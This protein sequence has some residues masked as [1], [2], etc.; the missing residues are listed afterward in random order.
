VIKQSNSAPRIAVIGCGAIAELYHLPALTQI[1]EIR[2]GLV[3]VDNNPSR[4]SAMAAKFSVANTSN[5][6]LEL[7]DNIDGAIVAT[8]PGSHFPIS[9]K[10]LE[11]SVHVLCE[12]PLSET[13]SEAEQLIG[14]AAASEVTLSVNQ[15]RRMFP[16]YQKIRQLIAAGTLGEIRSIRY[17]DGVEFSWPA[18]TGHH[19]CLG[20]KGAWSDTGI[21][22][23]DTICFW[24]NA[25]PLLVES[26]NDSFGGPEAVATVRLR[27]LDANIELKV[28]RLG[29]LSN[30]FHI[31]GTIGTIVAGNEDWQSIT[32]QFHNGRKRRLK[33]R[34]T[35]RGY[36]DFALPLM[37]N[38]VDVIKG[39]ASPLIPAEST[40]PG[41]AL[42]EEA[43]RKA[44][45]FEMPWNAVWESAN[46]S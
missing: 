20:A 29:R 35:A 7:I 15:T 18:A 41:V 33:L 11:N 26:R 16:T 8:P 30:Q 25:Q 46:V 17:H 39:I 31:E 23:L 9:A 6:Y 22:L 14:M 10:L 21:H 13:Y 3:L 28:S 32:I 19:F 2:S 44:T 45:P 40:L 24:L 34:T 4:L 42:L 5:N 27:H 1:P 12:K 36:N 37:Q 38:F 43:Y